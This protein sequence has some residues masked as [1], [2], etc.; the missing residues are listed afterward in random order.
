MKVQW[1]IFLGITIFFFNS[2]NSQYCLI[3]KLRSISEQEDYFED[4]NDELLV[5]YAS[6]IEDKC[7]D[8]NNSTSIN[9]SLFWIFLY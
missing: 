9:K 7:E 6:D 3:E 2:Y 1:N 5:S 4:I 8:C